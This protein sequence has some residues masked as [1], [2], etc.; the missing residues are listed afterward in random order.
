MHEKRECMK[1]MFIFI[2]G[3]FREEGLKRGF[4]RDFLRYNTIL[5]SRERTR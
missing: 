1:R 2:H 5:R 3:N 4:V